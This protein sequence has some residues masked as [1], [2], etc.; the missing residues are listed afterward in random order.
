MLSHAEVPGSRDGGIQ[1]RHD[2][3]S[4][5]VPVGLDVGRGPD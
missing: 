3:R 4:Q 2:L 5:A 1:M